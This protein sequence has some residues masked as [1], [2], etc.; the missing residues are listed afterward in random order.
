[1]SRALGS[2]QL[3]TDQG[4]PIYPLELP[5]DFDFWNI[6]CTQAGHPALDAGVWHLADDDSREAQ[7]RSLDF[8][9]NYFRDL[10]VAAPLPRPGIAPGGYFA[11]QEASM[12]IGPS[13]LTA[14]LPDFGYQMTLLPRDLRSASLARVNGWAVT[15]K[16]AQPEAARRLA[17]FLA[18]HPVHAG[19]SGVRESAAGSGTICWTALGEAVIPR[20]TPRDAP[21][22]QFLDQ[23][24]DQ[25]ARHSGGNTDQLYARIQA[26]YQSGLAPQQIDSGLPKPA[27]KLKPRAPVAAELRDM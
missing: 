6:L 18:R 11:R 15:A 21:L 5:A 26:E 8:I 24:I 7:M 4:Q 12:L 20:V 3:K 9:H 2:L 13:E 19:W 1:M 27:E 10:N 22:A 25:L 17:A 23:Q 14:S 16:S